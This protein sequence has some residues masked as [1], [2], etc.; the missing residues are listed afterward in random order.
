MSTEFPNPSDLIVVK[1]Y[2]P[3]WPIAFEEIKAVVGRTLGELALRIEHV[4]STSVPGL[5]A[6]PIIDMD[7]VIESTELLPAIIEKLAT[8]GYN[9]LGE[10]GIPGREAFSRQRDA[11]VPHD[12]SG[13][14]WP[15]HNLYVCARD[16]IALARHISFRDYLRQHPEAVVRYGAIKKGLAQ[17]YT[18]E[19]LDDYVD[20]KDD[21][22]RGIYQE[23]FGTPY[24]E[25]QK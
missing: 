6:K 13:R 10:R 2:D 3:Y 16:A 19:Q 23:I 20:G 15:R 17:R 18:N 9:H 7:V 21:F 5:A 14:I 25:N 11:T 12:G 1:D 4:G 24:D 22:I 8:L